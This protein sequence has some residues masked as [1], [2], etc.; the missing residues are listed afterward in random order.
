MIVATQFLCLHLT[1]FFHDIAPLGLREARE[2]DGQV[3]RHPIDLQGQSLM[4]LNYLGYLKLK[5]VLQ[6]LVNVAVRPNQ[7]SLNILPL[8]HL[9]DL[10]DL[11]L[12]L[13]LIYRSPQQIVHLVILQ[14]L[15]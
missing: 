7:I 13:P 2:E 12:Q 1:Q 3:I 15:V 9:D 10:P 11:M 6:K 14:F 5:Q 4:I 8:F